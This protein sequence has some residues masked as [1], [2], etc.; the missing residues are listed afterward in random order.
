MTARVCGAA[1]AVC[2]LALGCSPRV[3]SLPPAEWLLSPQPGLEITR[4]F[5]GN[6]LEAYATRFDPARFKLSLEW[7]PSGLRIPESIH[8]GYLVAL[9]GG[10]FEPDLRP[11]GLLIDQGREVH[12][13]SGGSGVVVLGSRLEL[14]RL[15]DFR[16]GTGLSALQAWPFL[17]E[18][19][20]TDGIRRDDGKRSRRSA[21]G[22]DGAGRGLLVAVVRDGVSLFQLMNLCR[23]L[24]ATVALNLDGGPSTGFALGLPPGWTSPSATEVSNALVLR[25][26]DPAPAPHLP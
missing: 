13:A 16:P 3:G 7:S 17:I 12:A 15:R 6:D 18:P 22:I 20:G 2:A 19:G 9:N 25:S 23:R 5:L 21:I 1:L 4:V 11:S 14:V 8:P 24:G 10:Y 26:A